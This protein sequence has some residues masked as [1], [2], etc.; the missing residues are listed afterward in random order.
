MLSATKWFY[1]SEVDQVETRQKGKDEDDVSD[2]C[3]P[4]DPSLH[5]LES[6]R[7]VMFV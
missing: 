3:Y 2:Q 5:F 6:D 7:M 1:K 4:G